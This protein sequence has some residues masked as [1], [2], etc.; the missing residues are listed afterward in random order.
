MRMTSKSVVRLA[1]D[2]L[3]AGQVAQA[4][5]GNRD[6]RRDDTLPQLSALLVQ[7][8]FRRTDYRTSWPLPRSGRNCGTPLVPY[9][10][11]RALLQ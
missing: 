1:R 4:Q 3:T 5:Y 9:C 2:A 7:R 11:D 10:P 8:Q 6:S